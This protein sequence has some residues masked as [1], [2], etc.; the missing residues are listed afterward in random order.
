MVAFNKR[1]EPNKSQNAAI[2][3]KPSPLMILAGAGTGKTFTLQN[4]IIHLINCYE[5]KPKHILAITYTEKAAKELK[6]RIINQIG[7]RAQTITVSTFHSFCFKI[8]KE[9]GNDTLPQLLEESEAIHIFLENFDSLGPFES[10][11]YPLNPKRAI[12]DSF[13]PF[14]S[15]VKDELIDIENMSIPT[16]NEDGSITNEIVN[17]LKDLKQIYPI[18]QSWKK[19]IKRN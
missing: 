9:F 1:F 2:H 7:S 5:V 3:H 18:F 19:K 4:R 12:N 16:P 8:L 17:Q 14:F 11:E 15:R 13:I 10:N 6:G